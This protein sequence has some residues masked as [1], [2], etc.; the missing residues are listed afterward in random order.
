MQMRVIA[1]HLE[2]LLAPEVASAV[3]FEMLEPFGGQMPVGEDLRL[4]ITETLCDTLAARLGEDQAFEVTQQIAMVLGLG[5]SPGSARRRSSVPSPEEAM[6]RSDFPTA[7][8]SVSA[9][10]AKVLVVSAGPGMERRLFASLGPQVTAIPVRKLD[11]LAQFIRE[12]TPQLVLVDATDPAE[13]AGRVAGTLD[14]CAANIVTVLWGSEQPFGRAILDSLGE[15]GGR[16]L[17]A[18]DRRE[19]VEPLLDLI[20]SRISDEPWPSRDGPSGV[21]LA[22]IKR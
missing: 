1:E 4:L 2:G 16:S 3:V 5:P 12:L 13:S 22:R 21:P 6:R 18:L 19:G 14:A 8:M 15:H 7:E 10:A 9:G 20:R 17:I 11:R